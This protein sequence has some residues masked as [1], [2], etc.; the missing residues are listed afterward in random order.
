M[1]A[2]KEKIVVPMKLYAP[3]VTAPKVRALPTEH[4]KIANLQAQLSQLE[5]QLDLA[6]DRLRRLRE[7]VESEVK[8]WQ[9]GLE[10][11]EW[12]GYEATRR[13]L[14][15]LSGALEYQGVRTWGKYEEL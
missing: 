14:S 11:G 6:K 10:S 15:R 8:F 1:S 12:E 7:V 2:R 3:A 13:R 9:H 5:T 4:D